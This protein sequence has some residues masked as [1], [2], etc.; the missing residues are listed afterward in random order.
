MSLWQTESWQE[1]LLA[2]WQI[3]EYFVV[4]Q[5]FQSLDSLKSRLDK[6]IF[7][8]KRRVS[9]GE[10]W[11]FVIGFEGNLD[12]NLE[13]N[14]QELCVEENCLFVQIETINYSLQPI[15]FSKG[16]NSS[17]DLDDEENWNFQIWKYYKKFIPPY[18]AVIDLTKSEEEI[19]TA[20]K[21]KGR[22]NIRLAEKKWVE[23]REVVK[24]DENIKLFHALMQETTSRD[25]FSGNI[26]EYYQEFLKQE[27]SH[28]FFAYHEDEVIAAGIFI[29]HH[30]VM[31]YYYGASSNHKRNLMT[32]YLLQWTAICFAKNIWCTLYDFLGIAWPDEK[33]SPL[34]GVTDFKLKLTPDVRKV[35]ESYL[36][37]HKKCKY[38]YMQLLKYLIKYLKK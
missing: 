23:V 38:Q 15:S 12:E 29:S 37:I 5:N 27:T 14:L 11:L 32:P 10:F 9:L 13:E 1:M 26:L 31:Y 33:N 18:T 20:M 16:E 22:Y 34:T 17:E 4:E 30:E 8:E 19:L 6:K 3:E 2:S 24:S 7:V 21:P 35:S 28:L 36:Y 25:N